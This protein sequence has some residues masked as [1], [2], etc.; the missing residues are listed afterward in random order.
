MAELLGEVSEWLRRVMADAEW[1]V[2][3]RERM[4]AAGIDRDPTVRIVISHPAIPME[5]EEAGMLWGHPVRRGPVGVFVQ[6]H[7]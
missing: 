6:R 4:M 7:G 1:L 5:V 2:M 3:Q